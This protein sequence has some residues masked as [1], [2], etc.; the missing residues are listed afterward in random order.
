MKLYELFLVILI[1][2]CTIFVFIDEN[3]IPT[4]NDYVAI[5][6]TTTTTT[7][8]I[9]TTTTTTTTTLPVITTETTA[10]NE[11]VWCYRGCIFGTDNEGKS[12]PLIYTIDS[13]R[14][15]TLNYK[16]FGNVMSDISMLKLDTVY[17]K[18]TRSQN[19][20]YCTANDHTTPL[21]KSVI[22]TFNPDL[23]SAAYSIL[24]AHG[25]K[26]SVTILEDEKI[27]AAAS[28]P[29]F[30]HNDIIT[31]NS[32]GLQ[33]RDAFNNQCFIDYA[34]GSAFKTISSVVLSANGLNGSIEDPGYIA[35]LDIGNWDKDSGKY[36]IS[37]D[38]TDATFTSSNCYFVLQFEKLG[39]RAMETLDNLYLFSS[40]LECDF[41]TLQASCKDNSKIENLTR[42][43]FGQRVYLSPVQLG[44]YSQATATGELIKPR[45]LEA[46]VDTVTNEILQD[47][48]NKEVLNTIPLEYRTDTLTAMKTISDNLGLYAGENEVIFTKTGT[49]EINQASYKDFLLLVSVIQDVNT[50][51]TKTIVLQIQNPDDL[52]YSYAADAAS[53]MQ[54][55]INSVNQ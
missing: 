37:R 20:T 24:E 40:P 2:A 33:A 4:T 38:L 10:V 52:G 41:G 23:Q 32:V 19:P 36:P 50:G 14:M 15:I 45:I 47:H 53:I 22:T 5:T 12:I 13:S 3:L 8:T 30:S 43:A 44:M 7:E 55:I 26:G 46:V 34:P 39:E 27:R 18:Y 29:D 6:N 49:A 28:Y 48:S 9:T 21:G 25:I 54:E 16:G 17:E 42:I 1:L 51:E 35:S 31:G 11:D